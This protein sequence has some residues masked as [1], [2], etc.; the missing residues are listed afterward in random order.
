MRRHVL[1]T[2]P[3]PTVTHF[4][5]LDALIFSSEYQKPQI[6][7]YYYT[8]GNNLL[9]KPNFSLSIRHPPQPSKTLRLLFTIGNPKR[10]SE[11]NVRTSVIK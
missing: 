3:S 8:C 9:H 4:M 1:P 5:N 2:A 6:Y 10:K 7:Y 11:K